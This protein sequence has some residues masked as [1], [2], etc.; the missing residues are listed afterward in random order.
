V[1]TTALGRT[2]TSAPAPVGPRHRRGRG[3]TPLPDVRRAEV[4]APDAVEAELAEPIRVIS[5]RI[6]AIVA[7]LIIAMATAA[8]WA[9]VGTWPQHLSTA[10]VVMHGDG[11]RQARAA[12]EG[13]V[14]EVDV[15]V[16]Q[17]VTAG[18][19]VAVVQKADGTR[20]TVVAPAAGTVA[21]LLSTPGTAVLP[22]SPIV[23]VDA[24]SAPPTAELVVTSAADLQRLAAGQQV[25]LDVDDAAVSGR[26][27]AATPVKTT[28][29]AVAGG[30]TVGT[31][32]LPSGDPPVWLVTVTLDA[33]Q[34]IAG[35]SVAKAVVVLPDIRVYKLLTGTQ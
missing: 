31:A 10:A 12:V 15:A 27:A 14:V 26:I 20:G 16:G 29:A 18:Q 30:L 33:G 13:S 34:Q 11:P 3:A 32:G 1:T 28:A 5:S 25:L 9:F 21:A 22:G 23:S 7:A 17:P 35:P 2:A 6:W 24:T 19:Q 4:D 8:V